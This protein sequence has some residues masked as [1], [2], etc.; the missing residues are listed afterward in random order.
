MLE[1]LT[2]T[3]LILSEVATIFEAGAPL[4]Q[5][6]IG[7]LESVMRLLEQ[8]EEHASHL[9]MEPLRGYANDYL[10][11]LA[12]SMTERGAVTLQEHDAR[13]VAHSVAMKLRDARQIASLPEPQTVLNALCA[14]HV[15]ERLTYPV[16]SFRFA[17]Q[18]FQEFYAASLLK[19][20][21]LALVGKD[22]SHAICEYAKRYVNEPA[23]SEPLRMIAG[24]IG[25]SAS[26]GD[27]AATHA[28]ALLIEMALKVDPVYAAELAYLCGAAVWK[29]SGDAL[30]QRLRAMYGAPDE[31]VRQCALA[32]MLASGS[33]DFKDLLIPLLANENQQVRLAS[34]RAWPDFHVSTFGPDWQRTM[35]GWNEEV[36]SEFVSE[37]LHFGNARE[38]IASFALADRSVKVK[39][40][41][42]SALV[43]G[44]SREEVTKLLASVDDATFR[45][46]LHELPLETIPSPNRARALAVY[47]EWYRERTD[48]VVRLRTLLL[49]GEVGGVNVIGELKDELKKCTGG[50]LEQLGRYVTRPA[51]DLIRPAE[52]EWV[53]HWVAERIIDGSLYGE[54]WIALVS[55]IPE[56]LKERLLHSIENE[57]F[58]HARYSGQVSI[59][60]AVCDMGMV[61]RIFVRLCTLRGV[62]AGAPDVK[63][64]LEWA[65]ERQLEELFRSLPANVAVA[66]L[67]KRLSDEIEPLELTVV[68]RLFGRVGRSESDLRSTLTNE[69]RQKL[70]RYL[71]MAVPVMLRED[72]FNG[73][74]KANL[75]S[76]LAQVGEPEDMPLLRELIHADIA[77][78]QRG[79]E[80]R[81]RGDRGKLGN[82]GA[83]SYANWHVRAVLQLA[84]EIADALLLETLKE[85]EYERDSAWG[86]VQLASVSKVEP[87]FGFGLGYT[88]HTDYAKIWEARQ[89]Q[90]AWS[91]EEDRRKRYA[92]AIRERIESLLAESKSGGQSRGYDFRLKELIKALAVIDS[93]GS[94]GLIL[95]L[96]A[97]QDTWNGWPVVQALDTLLF[98]GIVLPTDE[99]L[100]I[101]NTLLGHVRSHLWDDQ[102]VGLLIHALRLLPFVANAAS[103]VAKIREVIAELK[104]RTYELRDVAA[105]LGQS[106]CPEAV[107]L[108]REFASDE[109]VMRHLGEAWINAVAA[110]DFPESRQLLLSFVDPEILSLP[111]GLTFERD[112]VQAVRL[113]ELGLRDASIRQRLFQLCAMKPPPLK[114][115]LLAKAI[116]MFGTTEATLAGLSL[117]D[118]ATAPPVPYDIWKQLESNFVEHKPDSAVSNAYTLAPRSANSIRR[119]L[120][121]MATT[122]AQ[123]KESASSL[124]AQIEVWRLEH[125]RP[126]DEPRNP[127]FEC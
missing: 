52:P 3:P 121:E 91:F 70:R 94:T 72:D 59:L 1:E 117:I 23:W 111:A 100:G 73:E 42:I 88:R 41:G 44:G 22:D 86:L 125:G 123:R 18:Q 96:L 34:Y 77:R 107:A 68:T 84:P 15:L 53:S 92:V 109:V 64:D 104:L 55:S 106:R 14:H 114:R 21:L 33:E 71:V 62:I 12:V 19:R 79:M 57:D 67:A 7:V 45:A 85:N 87:A 29:E 119:R 66:A 58:K 36:R 83:M 20:Q 24:D 102:Q 81:M 9:Q 25:V 38:T 122:D 80:A 61:E 112:D 31:H 78:R 43:W 101:F 76:S 47:Q 118:D 108:L 8:S 51:L 40:T 48:P 124:L 4:P 30:A 37:L 10:D 54:N 60:A 2:Q 127:L 35:R 6:K 39:A 63:H 11:G 110:L 27:V 95:E 115:A 126:H 89:G 98:N 74:Q 75:A 120:F 16:D 26:G 99:T 32:G 13:A 28:G 90:P 105:A 17:H 116:G 69:L 93:A 49:I 113:A 65:V 5:T 50:T 82:G 97:S 103:G 56:E 46:A